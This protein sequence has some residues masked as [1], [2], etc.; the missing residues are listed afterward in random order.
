MTSQNRLHV[1]YIVPTVL[2]MLKFY[3]KNLF[4]LT[5]F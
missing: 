5:G 4:S 2:F 3:D 1:Q